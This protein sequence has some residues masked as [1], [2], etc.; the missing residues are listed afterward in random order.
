MVNFLVGFAAGCFF[1]ATLCIAGCAVDEWE[2]RHV[3]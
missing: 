1:V 3:E 2:D